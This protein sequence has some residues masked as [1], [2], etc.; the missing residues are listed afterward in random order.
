[1][2]NIPKC[3]QCGKPAVGLIGNQPLCVD[4][5]T[6]MAEIMQKQND[7]LVGAMNYLTDLM[8]A[9]VGLSGVLPHIEIPRPIYNRS[10]TTVNKV[11]IDRSIV[12]AVNQGTVDNIEVSLNHIQQQQGDQLADAIKELTEAIAKDSSQELAARDELLQVLQ[13]LASQAVQPKE[14][15][16]KGLIK[17]LLGTLNSTLSSISTLAKLWEKFEP[18]LYGMIS[19]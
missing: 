10:N 17:S 8:E 1:M 14:R 12:G 13:V 7:Q 5:Y 16:N 11:T 15:R 6:K 19:G 3:S 9:Q 2:P 18:I 4:H